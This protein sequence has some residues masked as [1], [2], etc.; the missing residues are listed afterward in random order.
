MDPD[1]LATFRARAD[2]LVAL[3]AEVEVLRAERVADMWEMHDMGMSTREIAEVARVTQQYV[4][5][6]FGPPK[7]RRKPR[8]RK[9]GLDGGKRSA[10]V[11]EQLPHGRK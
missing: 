6:V 10:N 5:Q 8:R 9:G 2:R 4:P 3:M 7:K 11:L 1:R